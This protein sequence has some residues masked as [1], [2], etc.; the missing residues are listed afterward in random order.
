MRLSIVLVSLLGLIATSGSSAWV[1]VPNKLAQAASSY[2]PVDASRTSARARIFTFSGDFSPSR[3]SRAL[4]VSLTSLEET[5]TTSDETSN[6]ALPSDFATV[7]EGARA[8]L[9][10]S[11][12]EPLRAKTWPLLDH[13]LT[14]YMMAC[15]VARAAGGNAE[16]TPQSSAEIFVKAV[17]FAMT[18]GINPETRF[19]FGVN[20]KAVRGED[21]GPDL[22]KFGTDFFRPVMDLEHSV[23]GGQDN[24][25]K[26]IAQL[27]AGENVILLANHQSEADPQVMSCL[28][29]KVG[30]GEYAENG[31]YVAG[32]KVTTDTLA[33]PFSMGRNLIC[34]HSKK[35]INA[36][37]ETKPAKS[38]ENLQA[39]SG[40]LKEFKKGGAL[41]WVAPSG[42]RDRRDLDTKTV[43]LAPFDSKTID[44]FRLMG[45]KSKVKTHYYP[46]AM[47]T[48]DLCPPPDTIEAGTGEQR[49]VRFV[50]VGIHFGEELESTGGL[51]K[52]QE[53]CT[54]AMSRCEEDYSN[55]QQAM[56]EKSNK[57]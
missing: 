1:A 21:G 6:E 32:H 31:I 46:L 18:Y 35:H 12:P 51:E 16:P 42:G 41:L 37:P 22:Y 39:M 4:R 40:M 11:I 36:D 54:T 50:P 13:F 2:C 20:H 47:V 19:K 25:N 28:M 45:N 55:L 15:A 33:I 30:F 5:A 23:V 7:L 14:Q 8:K 43:P 24:L 44:I 56:Q 48:Y 29:E 3:S 53:F 52:R 57:H 27:D 9:E 49:N 10:A 26:I 38:R 34:I 17:E